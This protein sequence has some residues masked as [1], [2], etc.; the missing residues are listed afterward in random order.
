MRTFDLTPL[1]RST[2]GFDRLNDMLDAAMTTQEQAVSYPPYNI[3]KY[4]EDRY[5]ITM[6]VA[7]FAEEDIDITAHG[8]QLT[9]SGKTAE[10]EEKTDGHEYLHKG[11][12]A[13]AFERKFSLADHVQVIG[14]EL[15]HGLL[16]VQ[17]LREVPEAHKPRQIAINGKA[18]K[19]VIDAKK[20]A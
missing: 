19:K 14:A 11:I 16:T 20:A 5:S 17:L 18:P 8:N 7:G 13:R 3:E 2:V 1:F 12:A 15:K 10:E 4:G 6:A 9:I